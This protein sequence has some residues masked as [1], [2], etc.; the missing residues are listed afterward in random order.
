MAT[1]TVTAKVRLL[2]VTAKVGLLDV[3]TKVRFLAVAGT[4]GGCLAA[5]AT[6]Q[7]A[8]A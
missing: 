1:A 4:V 6:C 2:A 8:M 3:T 7:S 5:T